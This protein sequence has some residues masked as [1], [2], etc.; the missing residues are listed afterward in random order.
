MPK[1]FARPHIGKV[2]MKFYF[3][4]QDMSVLLPGLDIHGD[5]VVAWKRGYRRT[6]TEPFAVKEELNP[7]NGVLTRIAATMQ[8]LAQICTMFKNSRTQA[9]EPKVAQ[10]TLR[11]GEQKLGSATIDLSS[12]ATPDMSS[13]P[14]EL[15]MLDGKVLIKFTLTSHWLKNAQATGSGDDDSLCS[16]NSYSE[17]DDD[18]KSEAGSRRGGR[19]LPPPV[20]ATSAASGPAPSAAA[21]SYVPITASEREKSNAQREAAIEQQWAAAEEKGREAQANDALREEVAELQATLKSARKEAKFLRER[22]E[23]L[24]AENRVLRRDPRKGKRDA[25]IEQLEVELQRK[26]LERAEMEEQLSAAFGGLI[27][28]M[29]ARVTGLTAERDRLLMSLNEATG[30]KGG[31]L[32]AKS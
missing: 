26:E 11:H 25:V 31:F 3:R 30:R 7:V 19:V 1:H 29:Q 8:D 12:Y 4:A 2:P 9:F 15:S 22:V 32:T 18:E 6:A 24:A 5:I 23:A 20:A 21:A 10:F 13:D 16:F 28:D 17:V 27:K 14:V